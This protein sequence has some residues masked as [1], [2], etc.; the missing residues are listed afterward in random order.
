MDKETLKYYEKFKSY[1]LTELYEVE[2][3]INKEKYPD[4]YNYLLA[5]IESRLSKTDNI[6]N[7]NH[8]IETQ[9]SIIYQNYKTSN[10][11]LNIDT[12]KNLYCDNTP[13]MTL[14]GIVYKS[15]LFIAILFYSA[16]ISWQY[17]F[18]RIESSGVGFL[19]IVIMLINIYMV[20]TTILIKKYTYLTAPLYA[21]LQGLLIG[22]L[23]RYIEENHPGVVFQSIM[24]TTS[25]FVILLIIY[26]FNLIPLN[27]YFRLGVVSSTISVV[28]IY[29]V[30]YLFHLSG[31]EF[32]YLHENDFW[33]ICFCVYSIIL[34]AF[35]FILDLDFIAHGIAQKAPKYMELY[36]SFSLTVTLIWLYLERL[37]L[38]SKFVKKDNGWV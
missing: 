9:S 6:L 18:N 2:R 38:F 7:P 36:S 20:F 27:K 25:I 19:S 24:I 22:C 1:S 21:F 30:T 34:A 12:F 37:N 26:L 35:N 13:I 33:G 8:N 5:E 23:S 17:I 11:V 3:A 4:R 16:F 15:F 28:I 32:P 31:L 14:R 29:L 10:P